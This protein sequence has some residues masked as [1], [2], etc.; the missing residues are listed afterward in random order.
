MHEPTANLLY[1]T[2]H[3]WSLAVSVQI[4]P[5][6]K[7]V[8]FINAKMGVDPFP[9][10]PG[11]EIH[12][13]SN[14]SLDVWLFKVVPGQ[15]H[16]MDGRTWVKVLKV[17]WGVFFFLGGKV[18]YQIAKL[19]PF[20]AWYRFYRLCVLGV[21]VQRSWYDDLGEGL[22]W[23]NQCSHS[24]LF[25][26]KRRLPRFSY[27]VSGEGEKLKVDG[28][29]ACPKSNSQGQYTLNSQSDE[30]VNQNRKDNKTTVLEWSC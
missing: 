26:T 15:G 8:V 11:V 30:F 23:T 3:P 9:K 21:H 2:K 14:V 7:P 18:A 24:S 4:F 12:L 5:K 27:W 10:Q 1:E 25:A 13:W 20:Q 17:P 6:Q 16:E 22:D 19:Q 28:D 29:F